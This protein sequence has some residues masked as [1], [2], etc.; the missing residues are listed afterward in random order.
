MKIAVDAMGGDWAPR[1]IVK[2]AV[3]AAATLGAR[4][5][6][7]GNPDQIA[8]L[9]TEVGL[10]APGVE[11]IPAWQQVEMSDKPV[12]ALRHKKESSL[13]VAAALVRNGDAG[14]LVSAGN[15]GATMAFSL[16]NFGRLPGVDR[17]G[18][19]I[20]MPTTRGYCMFIDGGAN[21]E[22]KPR[23]LLQFAH[24]GSLY[25]QSVLGW[26]HPKVALLNV[27]S[28]PEK[29]TAVLQDAY[30]LLNASGLNFIGNIESRDILSGV[31]DVVVTDGFSGNLILKFAEGLATAL[32]D[33]LKTEI[34]QSGL[35]VQLGAYLTRPAFQNLKKRMNYEEYGGALLLGLNHPTVICHGSS[36]ARAIFN[37]IRV[38]QESLS[39]NVT[40]KIADLM[41]EEPEGS[42]ENK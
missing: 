9:E 25:V 11:V 41:R 15:T 17:P 7:V 40:G 2:G 29:G 26:K 12:Y 14:A 16:R 13:A 28:E 32:L 18:I 5:L 42:R 27:G 34:K 10:P 22:A 19:A 21:L 20:P 33:M 23:Y 3:Q 6:L 35:G 1:E 39:Q 36:R 37:A 24:M 31:A 30:K 8:A 38:A 4:I